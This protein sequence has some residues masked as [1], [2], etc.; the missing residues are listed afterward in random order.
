MQF[1]RRQMDKLLSMDDESFK[2]LA[3]TIADAAGANK[4][5]TEAMLN[6]PELLKSRISQLSEQEAQSLID[7][8]GRE[9]SEE[10]MNMLRKRGVDLG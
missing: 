2:E 8:A 5:K 7:A 6:N 10:I 4:F 1:D 9:K 3:R